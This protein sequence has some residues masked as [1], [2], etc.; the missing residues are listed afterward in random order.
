MGA[1]GPCGRPADAHHSVEGLQGEAG[2]PRLGIAREDARARLRRVNRMPCRMLQGFEGHK[3]LPFA[4]CGTRTAQP[5]TAATIPLH[6]ALAHVKK[7]KAYRPRLPQPTAAACMM[8]SHHH[9]SV[10]ID[11]AHAH[12]YFCSTEDLLPGRAATVSVSASAVV[13]GSGG[14][15]CG[16]RPL[17]S[18]GL[19]VRRLYGPVQ[20]EQR[21]LLRNQQH[22]WRL[23]G[24]L[25]WHSARRHKSRA[26]RVSRHCCVVHDDW[27]A[28]C[29]PPLPSTPPPAL[30][31]LTRAWG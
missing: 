23:R 9:Q 28:P 13:V 6:T 19:Q 7:Q 22:T 20:R 15:G 10:I 26:Q 2:A 24:R 11:A 17:H 8:M 27:L 30:E 14:A 12:A 3:R 29:A 1:P 21:V 5:S 25:G 4:S 31:R 16:S 18:H